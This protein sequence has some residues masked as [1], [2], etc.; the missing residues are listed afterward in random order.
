MKSVEVSK[1]DFEAAIAR[2][3]SFEKIDF[4]CPR[5]V[6]D[7]GLFFGFILGVRHKSQSKK[8]W[9]WEDFVVKNPDG[10]IYRGKTNEVIFLQIHKIL[11]II[12]NTP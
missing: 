8:V 11:D 1:Q 2:A 5:N 4:A 12:N 9:T 7:P 10:T 3:N 6:M